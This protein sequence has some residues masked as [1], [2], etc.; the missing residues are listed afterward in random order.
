MKPLFTKIAILSLLVLFFNFSVNAQALSGS[1]I[2]SIVQKTMKTFDVPGMA[3][4]VL[5]DGKI[6][7]KNTYGVRSLKTNEAVNENTLFGVAS[8]TKAFTTAALGQ[9]IDQGKLT[10][11]TKVTDI[12][13]E[14]QLSDSY[15]TREF[16]IRDLITH[17]SGLGLGAGD[18]MVFPAGNTTTKAE[19][20]HNLRYL[21]P[22]S[23][24]RSKFDYDNLLYI[25]AG[26]VVSR[27]SG[28]SYDDY[29]SENFFKPLKMNRSLLSIPQIKADNN[30]IDG[31]APVNGKLELTAD[32]FTQIATPAGGIFASINDMSTWVQA[33]LND[34]KYGEKLEDSLFSSKVHREMW[35]PQTILRSGK[36]PYNT[37]FS[38]YGLGWFLSDVSG[39]FQVTHTGGLNGI[40][41]QVTLI[42]EMDLGIIVLT[43]QQSGAAFTAITNSIKD[44]YFGIK[45]E[46][47]IKQYNDRRLA[48]EKNEESIVAEV[49]KSIETQLKSKTPKPN[50]ED[51]T[52]NYE[53]VWFGKVAISN[54]NGT[55]HF[56]AEKSPDLTGTMTF[57]KGT[58][59]AVRWNDTSLKADAFVNFSLNTEGKAEGF[60]MSPISP[61]TDFSYDFQDLEFNK[62]K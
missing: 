8:N 34:G 27:I 35:T 62:M 39:Y 25:V 6:Y 47:R 4:A 24:F 38:A 45:G 11:D 53:D 5:K 10:W 28:K 59:Y 60:T 46:D 43:N 19:M 42:P 56:K 9:L 17:R 3:V 52:G 40:V 51:Y 26:E 44:A 7:H 48:G 41:S 33:Q 15:V 23:S 2:D 18:L 12:I 49:E 58:T 16:T 13:P 57:Y 50:P 54:Q 29:I 37:H 14:F 32:T 21:K 20:I 36:G 22:V 1:Q 31:H 30:R 61:L 55:L